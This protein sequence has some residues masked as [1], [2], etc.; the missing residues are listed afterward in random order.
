[1]KP[2]IAKGLAFYLNSTLVDIY[3]R[4]FN[5]HTQVNATDLRMLRYPGIEVLEA[6]GAQVTDG[7]FPPQDEIDQ[8]LERRLQRMATSATG[9]ACIYPRNT[10]A[11][12]NGLRGG[13]GPVTSF[14][15]ELLAHAGLDTVLRTY[16][17]G[18][19]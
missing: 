2:E 6:M 19:G 9:V 12:R 17:T 4:Q 5:G 16:S 7:E 14:V 3:F 15:V 13:N 8:A 11:K 10:S 1:M 18:V